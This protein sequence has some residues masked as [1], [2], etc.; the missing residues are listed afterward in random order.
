MH[1]VVTE[2]VVKKLVKVLIGIIGVIALALGAIFYFTADMVT[3]ADDFFVAAK[4]N[5]A[6]DAYAYLSEDFRANTSESELMEFLEENQLTQF[7]NANWQTRSI[8]GGR[9][10]LV[11]SITTTS[12][13]TVPLSLTFA[14]GGGTWSIYAIQKP[15]AGIS[16]ESSD[17]QLPSESEQVALVSETMQ[18]FAVSV[19]EQSMETFHGH[20][21]NLWQRQISVAELEEA[22]GAYFGIG[23]DFTVLE[24][25]APTF[26]SSPALDEE[27][28]LAIAGHYLVGE[29]KVVFTQTYVFEGL[30]WKLLGFSTRVE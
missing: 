22:F 28:F 23:A 27:G 20:L 4:E 15:K 6:S 13:G 8:N 18:M 1:K 3:V 7:E 26:D 30:S 10:D 21:S 14:K 5:R 2:I 16:E 19:N 24:T 9:G 12:G 17:L 25:Y 29:E 11:G